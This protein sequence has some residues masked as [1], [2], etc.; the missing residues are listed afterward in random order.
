MDLPPST[1]ECSKKYIIKI[2]PSN[3]AK[4]RTL[5]HSLFFN[6]LRRTHTEHYGT[7]QNTTR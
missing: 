1:A 2:S 3:F 7:L 4:K 5:E 6:R